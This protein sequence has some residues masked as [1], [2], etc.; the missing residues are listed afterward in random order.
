MYTEKQLRG[1]S[2]EVIAVL[3]DLKKQEK[4]SNANLAKL[5]IRVP[6]DERIT[7]CDT[8]V[9]ERFIVSKRGIVLILSSFTFSNSTVHRTK[10]PVRYQLAKEDE[11]CCCVQHYFEN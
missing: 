11:T 6:L 7:S 1:V 3:K 4:K 2:P 10:E 8:F 9:K 5:G